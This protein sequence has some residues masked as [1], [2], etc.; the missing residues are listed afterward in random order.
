MMDKFE[1]VKQRILE[2]AYQKDFVAAERE[3]NKAI[4]DY[5]NNA[6][7]FGMVA[8][9][10]IENGDYSQ[11]EAFARQAMRADKSYIFAY[12]LLA[13]IKNNEGKYNEA[14]EILDK[15]QIDYEGHIPQEMIT[16]ICN[17][18]GYIYKILGKPEQAARYYL[19]ASQY[20]PHIWQKTEN[21]SSYLFNLNYLSNISDQVLFNEHTKYNDLFLNIKQYQHKLFKS[22]KKIRIGYISPD[23]RKHVVVYFVYQL[24]KRYTHDL[25][26]VY[27]Y[28]LGQ[29]DNIS[30]QLKSFVDKWVN[31]ATLKDCEIAEL[32]YKDEIDILIDFA[33]HTRNNSLPILAYKPAPVQM[34]GIGYFNTTGLK[35]IDYFI[36]DVYVDPIGQNDELFTEKLLRL[37]ETHFCYTPPA[38]M[39]E[40][41]DPAYTKNGYITFGSF[42]NFTKVNDEVLAT[43][44][45]IL[46]KASNAKLLLKSAIFANAKAKKEIIKRIYLA[47]IKI[48]QV[49]LR[50]ESKDYLTE[51]KDV[52]IALDPFPYPGGA[53]TCEALYMGVP[54]ITLAGKRHGSR[55]GY[56]LLKN[57]N[58]DDCIA[59]SKEEYIEKAVALAND[60]ERIDFLH[61]NIRLIMQK[62]PLMDGKTY[63]ANIEIA[64]EKIWLENKL[65]NLPVD[66]VFLNNLAIE[67]TNNHEYLNAL[68]CGEKILSINQND[69]EGLHV[70]AVAYMNMNRLALAQEIVA[71]IIAIDEMYIGAYMVLAHIYKRKGEVVNQ[72]EILD[73]VIAL[74]ESIQVEKRT[75]QYQNAYSE[76]L[77]MLGAAQIL[78]GNVHKGIQSFLS[79]SQVERNPSQQLMEYSNYLLA[80]N[81]VYDITNQVRVGLHKQYNKF[82]AHVKRLNHISM[83]KNKIRVGYISPDFRCHPVMDFSM[84]L[85]TDFNHNKFEVFAYYTGRADHITEKIKKVVTKFT[86]INR[87][88]DEAAAK[89][90]AGDNIDILVDLSGHTANSCLS[91][92]AYKPAPVQICGLGYFNTTGLNAV[93]YFIGDKYCDNGNTENFFVEKIIRLPN[94]HFCYF[95]QQTF[96]DIKVLPSVKNGYIT[97]GSFNNFAKVNDEVLAIWGNILTNVPRSKIILKSKGF[98]FADVRKAV[99]KRFAKIGIE[100]KRIDLRDFS[101]NFLEEYNE[102]DIALDSF[103]YTGGATT[104]EALYMGVPVLTLCGDT[105][106]SRFGYSILKNIGLNDWIAFSKTEYI[107]KAT[108]LAREKSKLVQLRNSLRTMVEN[109]PLMDRKLYMENI[110]LEYERIYRKNIRTNYHWEN[111]QKYDTKNNEMEVFKG[112]TSIIILVHNQ[113]DYTKGCIESIRQYTE[114]NAYEIIIIDN[115]STDGTKEWLAQQSDITVIYNDENLGFPKGCN[116]GIAVAKGSEILLLNNDVVVTARWL[117]NLKAALYSSSKVG[118]VGAITNNAANRQSIPTSYNSIAEMQVFANENNNSNAMYWERRLKLIGFCMLI[119]SDIVKKI[120]ILDE[121]FTPGNFEDDDYSLRIIQEGYELLLCYDV[122]IHH[123]GSATFEKILSE[124]EQYYELLKVNRDKFTKKWG[125]ND[126]N[127]I[128]F[129]W[130]LSQVDFSI[131]DINILNIG[132]GCGSD[133]LRI[134]QINK[135]AKL[136]GIEKNE[137]AAR[138]ACRYAQIAVGNIHTMVLDYEK[139]QFDYILINYGIEN[140]EQFE[141]LLAK[142]LPYLKSTGTIHFTMKHMLYYPV[143]ANFI[144]CKEWGNTY[145]YFAEEN[146][147]SFLERNN[148]ILTKCSI[149]KE[150]FAANIFEYISMIKTSG[151][152]VNADNFSSE[153]CYVQAKKIIK[154]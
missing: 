120:G 21:Y 30:L 115:A 17:L 43:W 135:S 27:C 109:S 51:Y 4:K 72:I 53:T 19:K 90:I 153:F 136:Y 68:A 108:S 13:R 100:E 131:S 6:E 149:K 46:A 59:F 18:Y 124:A 154:I 133:F 122:F 58:L 47:G 16:L 8:G 39:V 37:P 20:A 147:K 35:A 145:S 94:S 14:I 87:I 10:Y 105:H 41:S 84:A 5:P 118:A 142:V 67:F 9:L 143:V 75:L 62:S 151:I 66:R 132:C 88:T 144:S 128:S 64:Y 107:E 73:M 2:F 96:P 139:E 1:Q 141:Q 40:C 137:K 110:E 65:I 99:Y 79:S 57:L 83:R 98:A 60:F 48:N 114:P 121:R 25:F 49:E 29:E 134:S 3:L 126:K 112:I 152:N 42:N 52:D 119:K 33:G 34:S 138:F 15:L 150:F 113:L 71:K 130:I 22:H 56:S 93:D 31:V 89:L 77:S 111:G 70:K 80:T 116:Q 104:C 103:P 55:F 81:Y 23:L 50:P 28:S 125:F 140:L 12:F 26:E 95:P 74:V 92:L 97:F 129:S 146:I 63:L 32:I 91:I 117:D 7:L 45:K 44:A 106:G 24:M 102:I 86:H 76:A 61:Q 38:T 69:C 123:Y 78:L 101:E 36:T 82:F 54:V 85:F 11:A 127:K 148:F